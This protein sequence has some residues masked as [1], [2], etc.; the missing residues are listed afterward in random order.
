MQIHNLIPKTKNK[1]TMLVGRGGKRGK[2]SGRGGKGQTARA[3]NKKRPEL[4]DFI[5]RVPKLRGRGVN[6]NKSISTKPVI[7]N[8]GDIEA[9]FE[10]NSIISPSTL[11]ERN[12]ISLKDGKVPMVKILGQG[13]ITKKFTIENC[14][15]SKQAK[16]KVEKAGG[17]VKA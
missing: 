13:E 5:K 14:I 11:I 12:T 17:T 2:T 8:L 3:G 16:D 1:K 6:S 4:R 7:V 15:I 10:N 9:V